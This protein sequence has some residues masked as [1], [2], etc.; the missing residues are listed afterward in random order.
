MLSPMRTSYRWIL[1]STLLVLAGCYTVPETG[2]S[3][4]IVISPGEE[5][6]MGAAAFADVRAKDDSFE[7]YPVESLA[8]WHRRKRQKF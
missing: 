7:A 4:M 2:R 6:E 3:S 5:A 1:A 8:D